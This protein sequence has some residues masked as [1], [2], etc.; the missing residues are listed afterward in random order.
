M[1]AQPAI[2]CR[3]CGDPTPMLATKLCNRCYELERR[4]QDNP[5]IAGAILANLHLPHPN[6]IPLTGRQ[7]ERLL[8]YFD[9]VRATAALGSPGMLIAQLRYD[10][11]KNIYTMEPC[12]IDHDKALP[13]DGTGRQ[14]IPPSTKQQRVEHG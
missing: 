5:E 10:S 1:N 8:P 2:A 3:L 9:R 12:F 6:R 13:L 7:A 14:E 4:V 11:Q